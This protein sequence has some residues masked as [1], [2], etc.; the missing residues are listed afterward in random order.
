MTTFILNTGATIPALGFGTWQ[1]KDDQENAVAEALKAGVRHID[2]ARV[3]GTEPM[4]GAAI[5]KSG[6]SR[7]E[8]FITT[9]LWNSGHAP[10]DVEPA[11]DAS[12]KDLGMDYVDLFLMHFPAHKTVS[13]VDTWKAMEKLIATRKTRAIGVSNFSRTEVEEDPTLIEIGKNYNRTGAQVALAW[14]VTLGHSVLPKSKTPSRIKEN[15]E[16]DFKLEFVDLEKIRSIDKKLRFGDM[17]K[18]FGYNLYVGLDGKQ[19]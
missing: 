17:S 5:S 1:D 18:K 13:Y 11:L 14:G 10:E 12:L 3:Y 19:E 2:T 15:L 16:G 9:K 4:V 8:L 6:I 7:S